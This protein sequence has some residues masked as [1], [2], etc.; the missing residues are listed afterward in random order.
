MDITGPY[1]LTPWKNRYL[2]MFIDNFTK[3]ME[4][5]PIEDQTAET[6][7]RVYTFQIVA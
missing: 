4:A 7:A 1:P 6:C 2:L 5:F 3:Y